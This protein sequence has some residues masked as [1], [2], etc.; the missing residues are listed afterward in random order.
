[1]KVSIE[2]KGTLFVHPVFIVG[3]Y[4]ENKVPNICAV[5]WGGMCCSEPPSVGISLR[6]VR[7]SYKNII[8]S[9][10]FT[11]NI[12]SVDQI[13]AADYSGVYSGRNE[14]KFETLGLTAVD[15]GVVNAPYVAEFPMALLCKLYKTIELG[16]HVQLIGEIIDVIA[17]ENVLNSNGLPDINQVKPFIYDSA[18]R[19]Y[20]ATGDYLGEAYRN[21]KK[22]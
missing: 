20:F 16:V 4:N 14:N 1:M 13:D 18:T 21:V 2:K 12:P 19:A 10:A 7:H 3:S 5:S 17:E 9:G 8:N 22:V 11:I 15:A 6:P